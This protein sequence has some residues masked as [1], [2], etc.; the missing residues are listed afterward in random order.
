MR[1]LGMILPQAVDSDYVRF[2]K[3]EAYRIP[4]AYQARWSGGPGR[5]LSLAIAAPDFLPLRTPWA[6]LT[7]G[8]RDSNWV[9]V[10]WNPTWLLDLMKS[11]PGGEIVEQSTEF[12]LQKIKTVSFG[13]DSKKYEGYRFTVHADGHPH[14]TI[15]TTLISCGAPSEAVPKSCQHRFLNKGRHFYFRHRPEDVPDWQRMQKR[16]LDLFASFE[17]Q[18]AEL[19]MIQ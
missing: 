11:A 3:I 2:S 5:R 16:V 10:D 4:K 1:G 6:D 19:P 18:G 8:A 14:S 15:N 17:V 7:P 12:G 13:R 9:F